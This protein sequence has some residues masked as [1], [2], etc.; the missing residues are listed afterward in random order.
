MFNNRILIIPILGILLVLGCSDQNDPTNPEFSEQSWSSLIRGEI[1]KDLIDFEIPAMIGEGMVDDQGALRVRGR[2]LAYDDE[3]GALTV[4]LSVYNDSDSAYPL[5]VGL[6]FVQF[7]PE[8]VTIL[9][10]DNDQNGAGAMILFEFG[11]GDEE[12]GPGEESRPRNV[13]FNVAAG[14][15][16][17]FM[18]RIDVGMSPGG[19]SIGGIV[20]MDENED[21][22]IDDDEGGAAGV[23]I[24]LFSGGD[25][26]GT[27]LD[28]AVSGDDGTYRFDTLEAGYYT[29]VRLPMEG[30]VGTTAPEMAV[31]LVEEDGMVS[32]FLLA[33]FGVV[34]E[35]G[36]G[37]D[38]IMVGDYVHAKGAFA[39]EP[40]RL[41]AEI[42]SI[43]HCNG[44][45]DDDDDGEDDDD[46]DDDGDDCDDGDDEDCDDC[47]DC[48]RQNSCWGRLAG[49]LTGYDP[50]E[51]YLE[52]MGTLVYLQE[53]DRP[54]P[55]DWEPGIRVRVEAYRD[56]DADDGRVVACKTPKWWNGNRD[57]VRGFVQEIIRGDD[58]Q[59]SG[60]IVLNT[61][62]TV[63]EEV[64]DYKVP[65]FTG[66][67]RKP[68]F[69]G[70]S[71]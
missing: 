66:A 61:M 31:I 45:K 58:D 38:F 25:V 23:T 16:I 67:M 30:L 62:I 63:S 18:A 33:N 53:K 28:Q 6:T 47:G 26:T 8:D 14:T 51:G 40:D 27:P 54:D 69:N 22:V 56:A 60:V 32:D 50:D 44:D 10:S 55:H 13:Q 29:V 49:P 15:S 70:V 35:D 68:G 12:W 3:L 24:A 43:C 7:I 2:N 1:S 34:M 21:G 37:E 39:E 4:D 57:R 41:I 36:A 46:E 20:W 42:F 52:I 64:L 48:C 59:I 65:V 9:N 5:P 19:G 11:E 17:G 71:H